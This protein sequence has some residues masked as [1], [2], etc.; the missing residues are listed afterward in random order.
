[1]SDEFGQLLASL[2]DRIVDLP[3]ERWDAEYKQMSRTEQQ[4]LDAYSLA[5]EC[6]IGG[7]SSYFMGWSGSHWRQ[8]VEA[9]ESAGATRAA[10]ALKLACKRFPGGAPS[11][12]PQ[13]R[14]DQL[15]DDD[16][17]EDLERLGEDIDEIEIFAAME[18]H[19]RGE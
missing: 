16:L 13:V 10:H 15:V 4:L 11:A 19:W 18:K 5:C 12:D 6:A 3:R 2:N 8:T 7:L 9:L 1:M 17:L 14:E